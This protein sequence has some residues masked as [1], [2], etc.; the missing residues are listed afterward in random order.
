MPSEARPGFGYSDEISDT[1]DLL[2]LLARRPAWHADAACKE[3]PR[4]VSWFPNHG[5]TEAIC[6][7]C[8]VIGECRAW[9]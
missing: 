1:G 5:E 9:A 6:A 8:L 2:E 7:G 3:A 4:E